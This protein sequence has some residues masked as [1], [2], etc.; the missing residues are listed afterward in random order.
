M[1][2]AVAAIA[3]ATADRLAD[4][5]GPHLSTAV[6]AAVHQTD[7]RPQQYVDPVAIGG[8]IVSVATLA[9]QIHKDLKK[10]TPEPKPQVV[11][12]TVRLRL[13]G[14]TGLAPADRDLIID[15]VVTEIFQLPNTQT[16]PALDAGNSGEATG[17]TP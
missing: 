4:R 3:R 17:P 7:G 12:R 9:W 5:Y 1:T 16:R 14:T 6:E 13:P 11:T 2:E 15:A 10:T 8:L